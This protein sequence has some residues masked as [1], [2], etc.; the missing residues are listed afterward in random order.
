MSAG[1]DWFWRGKQT[2]DGY[3]LGMREALQAVLF[4]LDGTLVQT[5]IDFPGMTRA[6]RELAARYDAQDAAADTDDILEIVQRTAQ[7]VGGERG[8]QARREAYH[9]LEAMEEKGCAHPVP[10]SG[11]S[12]LLARLQQESVRIAIITRNCRRVAENLLARQ[13]LPFDVLVAREDTQEFKP[14]PAP[15][16]RACRELGVEPAR[17]AMIGDLWADVAAGKAANV[18]LT[19]GIQWPHDPPQRFVKCTPDVLVAS[20][21]EAAPHL[22]GRT[23]M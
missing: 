10:I 14:H 18:S 1:W 6:T 21:E 15:V 19:I 9:L 5:F 23:Q 13:N 20:L 4:D 22:L 17:C 11:A 8:E 16:L 7:F 12:E 2:Q 3:L